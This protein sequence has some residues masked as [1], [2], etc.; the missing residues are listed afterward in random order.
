MSCLQGTPS[1]S[2][3]GAVFFYAMPAKSKSQTLTGL[4]FHSFKQDGKV[5]WQGE[6]IGY[7]DQSTVIC[8]LY[9]WLIGNETW[10]VLVPVSAMVTWRFYQ[11]TAQMDY[12]LERLKAQGMAK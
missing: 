10:C 8:Q 9:S 11:N 2:A 12:S 7:A 6:V 5:E 1:F 4:Y 3:A